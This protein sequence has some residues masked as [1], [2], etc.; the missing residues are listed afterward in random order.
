MKHERLRALAAPAATALSLVAC[1]GTL[2]AI[3]LLGALGISIALDEAVWAGAILVFAWLA[4]LALWL[5]Q[6]RHGRLWPIVLAAIGVALITFTMTITYE[7]AIEL[8]GFAFLCAG[9]FMDWRAARGRGRP[10]D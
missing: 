8:A 10:L 6:R 1:Y 5:R 4:L 3:G 9:T 7:R 2:A